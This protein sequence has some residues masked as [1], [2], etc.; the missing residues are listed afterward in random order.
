MKQN[1]VIFSSGTEI[2]GGTG[3][4]NLVRK[5][6]QANIVIVSNHKNGGTKAN[7]LRFGVPFYDFS[8]PYTADGYRELIQKICF[9]KNIAQS[10]LWYGLSGWFKKVYWLDPARTFNIH[11]ASLPRFAGMYG[12]KLHMAVWDAYQKN[13]IAEGE[14]VMHF[15]TEEYDKGPI[16]FRFPF[17][18][19]GIR[20]YAA[21]RMSARTLE[22]EF[23]PKITDL[24]LRGE[25]S[26]DG[27]YPE[28][29]RVPPDYRYL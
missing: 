25:I 9:E 17:S 29:L 10:N 6:P 28:S 27:I 15:V 12:E 21:Y 7:A 2:A 23:Q 3:A 13:E 22:H 20:S 1:L 5:L 26:W 19:F 8:G 14:I 24:V 4:A 11:P 16:F 18:L